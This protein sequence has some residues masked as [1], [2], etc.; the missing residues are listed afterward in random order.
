LLLLLRLRLLLQL[1]L[2][3]HLHLLLPL[4][5][6]LSSPK[7]ICCRL[8]FVFCSHSERSEAIEREEKR[9]HSERSEEPLYLSSPVV[10]RPLPRQTTPLPSTIK[11]SKT[12]P[13]K[14]FCEKPQQKRMSSPKTT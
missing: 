4:P 11:P 5:F 2:Q 14:N 12:H 6:L 10:A 7:G 13:Q 1:Q 9:R 3:L 8:R